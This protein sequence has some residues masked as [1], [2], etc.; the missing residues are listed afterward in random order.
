MTDQIKTETKIRIEYP[1][2]SELLYSITKQFSKN[3]IYFSD[4]T[5]PRIQ[6]YQKEMAKFR[7]EFRISPLNIMSNFAHGL[8]NS[9]S[10]VFQPGPSLIDAIRNIESLDMGSNEFFTL[11]DIAKNEYV[12]VDERIEDVLGYK[13]EQFSL[14]GMLGIKPDCLKLQPQDAMHM[15]RAAFV[16]YMV[17]C[18]PGFKWRIMKDF[19]R[20]RTRI[21]VHDSRIPEIRDM[22][23]MTLE[24]KVYISFGDDDSGDYIPTHHLKKWT[25]YD[26]SE[27]SG[28]CPYFGSDPYQSTY[29]NAYWYLL[30]A[31]LLEMP[32]K[33]VLLLHER[34]FKDRYK[35][36]A[37]SFNEHLGQYNGEADYMDEGQ[38]ADCFAKTI[39]P[40]I[41]ELV[42]V[43]ENRE[44]PI[45]ITSDQEA[46]DYAKRMGLL[47]IPKKVVELM[48]GG[49][50]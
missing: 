29:R 16:A 6:F 46:L 45:T 13:P 38:V 44:V 49:V 32:V 9:S 27:Y 3:Q 43:W 28:T 22:Q 20:A 26:E 4:E 35:A 17:S 1:N 42:N 11:F 25:V 41:A 30:H 50:V 2:W 47:P 18:I 48:Y 23:V 37:Q 40:R 33:F 12:S 7:D 10:D 24:K 14:M 8:A 21:Y 15:A 39:R 19:Y 31:F 5:L 34:Q 36:I